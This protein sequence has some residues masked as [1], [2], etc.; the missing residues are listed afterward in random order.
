INPFTIHG[1]AWEPPVGSLEEDIRKRTKG[2]DTMVS[3]N[4]PSP[5]QR[6]LTPAPCFAIHSVL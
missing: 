5:T 2:T 4:T 1:C 3:V 6:I